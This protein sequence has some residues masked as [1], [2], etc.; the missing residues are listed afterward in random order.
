MSPL[1]NLFPRFV[2][3]A[4]FSAWAFIVGLMVI[5][6]RYN[7]PSSWMIFVLLGYQSNMGSFREPII[8]T[9]AGVVAILGICSC[10]PRRF[11]SV[12]ISLFSS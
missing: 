4:S 12:A 8:I 7:V 6:A 10:I 1:K 5:I 9:W 11:I 3:L 2:F